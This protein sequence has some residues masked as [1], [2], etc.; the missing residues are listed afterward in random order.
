MRYEG[1][2]YRP[3]SEAYSLILQATIGCSHN[4]CTFCIAFKGKKYRARTYEEIARDIDWAAN[5][6]NRVQRVF[7]AD[8]NALAMETGEL[9]KVLKKLYSTLPGLERVGIYGG[10]WD[11]IAKTPEE[12]TALREAGLNIV[13]LGVESGDDEILKAVVKGATT[14]EIT[15]ASQKLITAGL[16]LSATIIIGLGGKKHME[17]H[18]RATARLINEITPHYLGA[19]T[20][21]VE[22]EMAI[23]RRVTKGELELLNPFEVLTEMKILIENLH[24]KNCTFRSNHASNYLPIKG[25]L[26][27]DKTAIV[28]LIDQVLNSGDPDLLRPERKR[29]L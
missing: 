5:Q 4:A 29:A 28:Q 10:P 9:L 24:L 12:L 23:A 15:I 17:R 22:P 6:Y 19:L 13:Y 7:L 20:L 2:I 26:D 8:G 18:A 3:P 14:A 21:M 1:S 27:Q 16:T 25:T 11:A